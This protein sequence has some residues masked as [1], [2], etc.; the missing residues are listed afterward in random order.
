MRV[1]IFRAC[2][3]ACL[4]AILPHAAQARTAPINANLYTTYQFTDSNQGLSWVTCGATQQSEGCFGSGQLGTFGDICAVLQGKAKIKGDTVTQDVYV[5]DRDYEG[6]TNL[7]LDVYKKTDVIT[8][9]Y[10]TTTFTATKQINLQ[11]PAGKKV[12]CFAAAGPAYIFV[13]TSKSDTAVSISKSDLSL[14]TVGGFSPPTALTGIQADN[15]GYVSV[16]FGNGFYLFGP[17]GQG[18]EDGGGNALLL[19]EISPLVP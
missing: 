15:R 13:G 4:L 3:L 9:S 8:D 2:V 14:G 12:S 10:D 11:L 16:N 7:Y 19:N 17:N 6:G 18:E 5:F 1:S